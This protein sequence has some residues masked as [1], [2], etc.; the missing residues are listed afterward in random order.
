M[1]HPRPP[2]NSGSESAR[3]FPIERVMAR[4]AA[5]TWTP[6][7]IYDIDSKDLDRML[8]QVCRLAR[9]EAMSLSNELDLL[10]ILQVVVRDTPSVIE[11]IS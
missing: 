2:A 1:A 8:A 6:M 9:A 5:S 11:G 10:S 3:F 7:T 4:L